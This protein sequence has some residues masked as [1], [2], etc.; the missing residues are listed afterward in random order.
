MADRR[1][2]RTSGDQPHREQVQDV[3]AWLAT[4]RRLD[5]DDGRTLGAY[6]AA[7]WTLGLT[8]VLPVTDAVLAAGTAQLLG[9]PDPR[10]VGQEALAAVEVLQGKRDGDRERAAGAFAF[11]AWWVGAERLPDWL[12]PRLEQLAG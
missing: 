1:Y 2:D 11:L 3:W 8:D 4:L 12:T 9:D 5:P 10:L 6:E 7:E